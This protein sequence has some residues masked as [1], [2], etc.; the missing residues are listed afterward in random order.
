MVSAGNGEVASLQVIPVEFSVELDLED[1]VY[2][3]LST[4]GLPL[5]IG[6][7]ESGQAGERR[8]RACPGSDQARAHRCGH[9]LAVEPG[10]WKLQ[11]CSLGWSVKA[12]VRVRG[13][14]GVNVELLIVQL[15]RTQLLIDLFYL[16]SS[17]DKVPHP[18]VNKKNGRV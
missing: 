12:G 9:S 15:V 4:Y 6:R 11:S 14:Q 10:N 8:G 3:Q 2:I 18:L 13:G 7:G 1:L 17:S 16:G 5:S